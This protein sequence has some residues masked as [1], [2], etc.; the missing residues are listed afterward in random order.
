MSMHPQPPAD[1]VSLPASSTVAWVVAGRL[2]PW[3]TKLRDGWLIAK[4]GSF[5]LSVVLLASLSSLRLE[6]QEAGDGTPAEITGDT[7]PSATSPSRF[8]RHHRKHRAAL[9]ERRQRQ[10]ADQLRLYRQQAR[11][12]LPRLQ[13]SHLQ[14]L[15]AGELVRLRH[16]PPEPSSPHQAVGLQ[17]VDLP[18][19][20]LWIAAQDSHFSGLDETLEY[21]LSE[22]GE[23][24][25]LW[26][27]FVDLP[28]P[29]KNRRW[30]VEVW[31]NFELAASPEIDAWEHGW[32][33]APKAWPR[34]EEA[35]RQGLVE[36]M[37]AERSAKAL[38]T[39][40]NRGAWMMINMPEGGTLIGFHAT[41]EIG[42]SV[43]DRLVVANTLHGLERLFAKVIE[44]ARSQVKSHY[45]EDHPAI[46]GGDGNPIPTYGMPH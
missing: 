25:T 28:W 2:D 5:A 43:P 39:P 22:A 42:G 23:E 11:L 46:L 45:T 17:W 16:L 35:I 4:A 38:W 9:L 27:G 7:A 3:L 26:F 32:Q 13:A 33:L 29:L 44:R 14:D 34:A 1:H 18:R 30:V 19:N 40:V 21:R 20:D 24:P 10:L 37:T 15:A 8:R 6:A 12:S 36:G 31:D 41:F